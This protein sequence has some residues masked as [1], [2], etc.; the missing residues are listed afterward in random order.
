MAVLLGLFVLFTFGIQESVQAQ[1]VSI[2]RSSSDGDG[3]MVE[4]AMKTLLREEG[5]TVK[6]ATNEGIVLM[7][8]AMQT[9]NGYGNSLGYVGH[10]TII[11]T[12]WHD[13]ADVF[14]GDQ[15][16]ERQQ[17]SKNVNDVL[18]TQAIYIGE[19][20]AVGRDPA[21]LANILVTAVNPKLRA[22]FKK[23]QSFFLRLD[24]I[25]RESRQ[26]DVINPMR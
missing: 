5:Y 4:A 14:V 6:T 22:S 3:V 21:T 12:Q 17:L 18:G 24:E 1:T 10:L 8:S 20:L 9:Q 15:C 13:F 25:K 26:A 19:Q 11:S 7:L 16:E 23:M 2:I